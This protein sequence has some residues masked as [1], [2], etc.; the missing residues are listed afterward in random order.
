[1]SRRELLVVGIVMSSLLTALG[2]VV[3]PMYGRAMINRAHTDAAEIGAAARSYT[4]D[5]PGACP[6]L[7]HVALADPARGRD[8][9]GREFAIG[10]DGPAI[11]VLSA[12]ADG[13]FGTT[14]DIPHVER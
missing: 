11:E 3:F 7:E 2:G 14:D 5:H 10:C 12:G 8:P 1:M 4:L 13:A 9:W 6:E